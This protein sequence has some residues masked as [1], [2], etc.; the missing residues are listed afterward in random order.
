MA[1]PVKDPALL[2]QWLRFHPWP[3]NF[4]MLW[5]QPNEKESPFKWALHLFL[6]G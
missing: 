3:G 2:L 1:Q 4:H 6:F 5:A